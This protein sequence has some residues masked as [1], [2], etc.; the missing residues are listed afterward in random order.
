MSARQPQALVVEHDPRY[1]AT[2]CDHLARAGWRVAH[3]TT[4]REAGSAWDDLAADVV[5]AELDAP[6][7]DG[8]DLAARLAR[9]SARPAVVL[10]TTRPGALLVDRETQA[11]LG[12]DAILERPCRL[13]VLAKAL[14]DAAV[15]QAARTA[16]ERAAV[17]QPVTVPALL[18]P[19]LK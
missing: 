6:G 10:W 19:E 15:A 12:V 9:L 4:S 11:R 2:V 8:L 3:V 1:A 7:I 18:Q 14:S 13:E 17:L 16:D 5:L